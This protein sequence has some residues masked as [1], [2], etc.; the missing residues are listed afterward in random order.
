MYQVVL[1]KTL[2]NL[3][4]ILKKKNLSTTNPKEQVTLTTI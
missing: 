2:E 4:V 1:T 3:T